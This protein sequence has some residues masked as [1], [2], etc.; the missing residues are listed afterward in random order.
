MPVVLAALICSILAACGGS[1]SL[2]PNGAQAMPADDHILTVAASARSSKQEAW[3][4]GVD[5]YAG[6]PGGG[7]FLFAYCDAT[8]YLS[9]PQPNCYQNIPWKYGKKS[10]TVGYSADANPCEGGSPGYGTCSAAL[11]TS[12]KLG[13]VAI[14]NAVSASGNP[15]DPSWASKGT[16]QTSAFTDEIMV[17][18]SSLPVGSP[19]TLKE[20]LSL[21]KAFSFTASS[22]NGSG[23]A[24]VGL[25][26]VDVGYQASGEAGTLTGECQ[27]GQFVQKTSNGLGTTESTPLQVRVGYSYPISLILLVELNVWDCT[28]LTSNETTCASW[29]GS[30]SASMQNVDVP[31]KLTSVTS[32]VTYTT[33]SGRTYQ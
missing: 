2:P 22:S 5:G 19:A 25:I 4:V 17:T 18:S 27:N 30:S 28:S 7:P 26:G 33:A 12:D 20:T 29:G 31:Y 14:S 1:S 13:K 9:P 11:S 10:L 21:S 8:I 23:C 32:G 16:T 15:S 6:G 3:G 24:S